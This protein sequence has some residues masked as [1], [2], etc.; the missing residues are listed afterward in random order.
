MLT[1]CIH[2]TKERFQSLARQSLTILG[3]YSCSTVI[4]QGSLFNTL[5]TRIE[6][7]PRTSGNIRYIDYWVKREDGVK[8]RI[9][10]CKLLAPI[11][12]RINVLPTPSLPLLSI[13]NS[14]VALFILLVLVFQLQMLIL[15][16]FSPLISAC[17]FFTHEFP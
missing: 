9:L 12:E 14:I 5:S 11:C 15:Q 4:T 6:K 10:F 3:K 8:D 1:Q 2:H 7:H 17:L 13:L 16:P